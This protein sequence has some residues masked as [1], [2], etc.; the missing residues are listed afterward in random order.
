MNLAREQP[1]EF[2]ERIRRQ[3]GALARILD[4]AQWRPRSRSEATLEHAETKRL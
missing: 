1:I 2:E 4:E 3:S